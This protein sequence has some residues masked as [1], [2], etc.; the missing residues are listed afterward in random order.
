MG[1]PAVAQMTSGASDDPPI[2]H[3]TT[4]SYPV[5]RELLAQ[6]RDLAH[7]GAVTPAA[8][9]VHARRLAASSSAASPH[10]VWSRANSRLATRSATSDGTCA[11]TASAAA[12]VATTSSEVTQS[13]SRARD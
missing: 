1:T 7:A 5:S 11:A 8:S 12:P 4:R 10:N 6:C 3:S 2:P 9:P 13:P